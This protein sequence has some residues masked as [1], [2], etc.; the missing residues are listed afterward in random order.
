M[1]TTSLR[2]KAS[3]ASIASVVA[4]TLAFVQ[5]AFAQRVIGNIYPD[6]TDSQESPAVRDP[7]N[8]SDFG[9]Y[10]FS[11]PDLPPAPRDVYSEPAPK[12]GSLS[13]GFVAPESSAQRV[14]GNI[15][16]DS[17]DSQE[18]PAVRDPG[19]ASHFGPYSTSE[20]DLSSATTYTEPQSAPHSGSL[21]DRFC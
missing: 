1:K 8:A 9:P 10:S 7:G 16:P 20:P 19:D 15:Y 13:R 3:L 21:Y 11:Q 4:L 5:P 12:V 2:A 18:S 6:S 17:T 14:I